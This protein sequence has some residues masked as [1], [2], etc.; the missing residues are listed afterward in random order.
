[1][2]LRFMG[3]SVLLQSAVV[4]R[5]DVYV[6][7]FN[8]GG[9]YRFDEVTGSRVG[10]GV[11]I[12]PG[13]GGLAL[14]HG[15]LR[16]ADGTFLVASAGSDAV[17]RYAGDGAFLSA[18]IANGENGVPPGTLD[19]PVDLVLGAGGELLVSSQLNDRV[20]KF[21]AADGAFLGDVGAPGTI[22]G[23]SGLA[24]DAANGAIFGAGR[25][26]NHVR[27]LSAAGVPSATFLPA[28]FTQPF[29]VALEGAG[30]RLFVADGNAQ[31]VRV[32][33]AIT[34]ATLSTFTGG[35]SLPVGVRL[36]PQG[37]VCVASYNGD[38]VARFD[39]ATGEAGTD[40]VTPAAVAAAGLDGP[41]FFAF[42]PNPSP[43]ESWRLQYFGSMADSGEAANGADP[44]HDG[45]PNLL[46]FAV[47]ARP[48]AATVSPFDVS[49]EAGHLRLRVERAPVSG[50]AWTAEASAD[51]ADWEGTGL[52]V[53]TDDPSLLEVR[54]ALPLGAGGRKFLRFRVNPE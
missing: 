47:G 37:A 4:V 9:V 6:S 48:D 36:D 23:P 52:V 11:F 53:V 31:A 44:D 17:L 3:F 8:S 34:G 20:L 49:T 39:A 26:G 30:G 18:F 32:V 33:D 42:I 1:M 19:Y 25:F 12:A 24:V 7:G 22:D 50:V 29:G 46:E 14:P 13:S 16:L 38:R 51:L 45:L 43:L 28:A 27:R 41:N 10:S 21:D 35:L 2:L 54:D 15:V 5:A 40:V